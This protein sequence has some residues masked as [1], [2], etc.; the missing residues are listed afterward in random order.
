MEESPKEAM[1]EHEN[2]RNM[3][4]T[5]QWVA[6]VYLEKMGYSMEQLEKY[7]R[8]IDLCREYECG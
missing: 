2:E 7:L 6:E 1:E 5:K 8:A 4:E 3:H